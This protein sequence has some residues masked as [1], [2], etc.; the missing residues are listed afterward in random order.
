MICPPNTPPPSH[1]FV[2]NL[3]GNTDHVTATVQRLFRVSHTAVP[4]P[5]RGSVTKVLTFHKI[6]TRHIIKVTLNFVAFSLLSYGTLNT[7]RKFFHVGYSAECP[8]RPAG[9]A[10][11]RGPGQNC[12]HRGATARIKTW[13]NNS[14]D[15]LGRLKIE[16][17]IPS[18]ART[19]AHAH[20]HTHKKTSDTHISRGIKAA[21]FCKSVGRKPW[22]VV[23][24]GTTF[25]PTQIRMIDGPCRP[26]SS[27]NRALEAE[28]RI[29]Q[30]KQQPIRFTA[31]Q[32]QRCIDVTS[33]MRQVPAE[34]R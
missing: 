13:S 23:F 21:L 4:S 6:Q 31:A 28:Q 10:P 25:H 2:C 18:L 7:I 16:E 32:H 19:H 3:N 17:N 33:P 15:T 29:E 24:Q 34:Q 11:V 30:Q 9:G 27:S 14:C 8:R 5:R 12:S 1:L 20:T 26:S 22:R